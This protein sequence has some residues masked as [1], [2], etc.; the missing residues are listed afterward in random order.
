MSYQ[1]DKSIIRKD[2]LQVLAA[3]IPGNIWICLTSGLIA[4]L[5]THLYMLVNKLPNWDD[6][7][8][9]NGYGSGDSWGRW[10]L[11]YVRPLSGEWSIPAINGVMAIITIAI[12]SCLIISALK[13][14]SLSAAILV[15]V[16]AVTFPGFTSTMTFMFT[17]NSY[18]FG[19][20]FCC[21]GAFLIR[22]YKY[23]Y[24]PGVVFLVLSMGIYQSYICLAAG[25]LVLGLLLDLFENETTKKIIFSGIKS[26]ISLGIGMIAYVIV[27]KIAVPVLNDSQGISKMGQVEI[28]RI[29]RLIMRC[30]KRITEY[31]ILEPYSFISDGMHITNILIC[32]AGIVAFLYIIFNKKIYKDKTRLIIAIALA[33]M[34]PL[35]LA[36]IYAL[37]PNT[38]DAA[39][40]MLY[41]YFFVYVV[42]IALAEKIIVLFFNNDKEIKMSIV[43]TKIG[44]S[45]SYISILLIILVAYFN[46]LITNE[47][48]FRMDI[49]YQH[50][51]AYYNRIVMSIE[52]QPDYNYGD[53]LLVLGNAYPERY[54]VASLDMED[55]RFEEFSGVA[56][57]N[58]MLTEGVRIRFLRTYLGIDIPE[59]TDEVLKDIKGTKEYKQMPIYPKSG[60]IKLIKNIWVVKIFED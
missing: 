11:K 15:P 60:S 7:W 20:L 51:F 4:G 17:V 50:S 29:P 2:L 21:L 45:I 49:A 56:T 58:G 57:E 44:R 38:Q 23:G 43:W 32:V 14:K 24:I 25:I 52:E 9:F 59:Y 12:A 41:Q 16:M 55:K 48:Y 8:N 26:I 19:V 40:T 33:I 28:L 1:I 54:A 53:P 46:Y 3:K 37:A 10:F 34:V 22:K 42:I 39:M 18:A 47:A 27:S 36:S 5:F 13:L 30:Y 6:I 35:A 31:F